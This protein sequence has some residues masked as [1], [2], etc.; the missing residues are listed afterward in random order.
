MAVPLI[1][2]FGDSKTSGTQWEHN[3]QTS[4]CLWVSLCNSVMWLNF[5]V[6]AITLSFKIKCG[7]SRK[8]NDRPNITWGERIKAYNGT[9]FFSVTS[10]YL[11]S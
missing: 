9:N 10:D 3:A 7:D 2:Y 11:V 4:V 6:D 1:L 8:Q 5:Q